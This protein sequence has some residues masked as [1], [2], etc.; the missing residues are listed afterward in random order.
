[1]HLIL[2]MHVYLNIQQL[3]QKGCCV[4]RMLC[5]MCVCVCVC[6]SVCA[7]V[8]FCAFAFG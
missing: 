4:V 7:D 5:V 3:L 1:M 2:I 8:Y 6:F